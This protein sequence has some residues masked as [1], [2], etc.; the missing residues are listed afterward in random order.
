MDPSQIGCNS[1]FN[2]VKL[3][4]IDADFEKMF[5]MFEDVFL[6]DQVMEI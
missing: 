3:I 5:E 4:E 6:Q 2:L 1:I